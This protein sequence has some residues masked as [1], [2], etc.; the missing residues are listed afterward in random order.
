[1]GYKSRWKSVHCFST[2][3]TLFS[4]LLQS[5]K[6]KH[7]FHGHAGL[8][9]QETS[10]S[11]GNKLHDEQGK[12]QGRKPYFL[13]RFM[14][15]NLLP[16]PWVIQ[17]HFWASSGFLNKTSFAK[18]ESQRTA[19]LFPWLGAINHGCAPP[20][21]ENIFL[22]DRQESWKGSQEECSTLHTSLFILESMQDVFI[23]LVHFQH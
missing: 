6:R 10:A 3:V 20:A 11:P 1:M 18:S 9:V 12:E 5:G 21:N 13:L 7:Y 8:T 14:L 15:E 17:R 4:T 22:L 23:L 19:V 2:S 16:G